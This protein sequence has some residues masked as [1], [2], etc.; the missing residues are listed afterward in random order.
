L[1]ETTT[2]ADVRRATGEIS[3]P[4]KECIGAPVCVTSRAKR[5]QA[6]QA[7]AAESAQKRGGGVISRALAE[8]FV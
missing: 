1:G 8:I 7:A 6:T 5:T 3:D 4:L 2:G